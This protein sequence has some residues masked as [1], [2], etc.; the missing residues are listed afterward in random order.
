MY[1]ELQSFQPPDPS[2]LLCDVEIQNKKI[3]RNIT[4]KKIQ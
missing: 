4:V 3:I 1:K 2:R